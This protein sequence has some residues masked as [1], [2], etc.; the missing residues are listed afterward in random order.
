MNALS[1][2]NSPPPPP[3]DVRLDSAALVPLFL[4]ERKRLYYLL[5][6]LVGDP[7]EAESL[8]QETFLQAA[9]SLER[10]EGR[11]KA[12]TW[13]R[14]IA[15]NLSRSHRRKA[16]RCRP[17]DPDGLERVQEATPS[18]AGSPERVA[19]RRDEARLV[20][21]ALDRLPAPYREVV[22]LRDLD[23]LSTREVAG[24]LG[25]AEGAVRVR[26]HRA[27]QALAALLAPYAAEAVGD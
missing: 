21:R 24:R 7:H 22:T 26:L 23:G 2:P 4:G 17:L 25:V 18:G 16:A 15:L 14:A 6:R 27:R 20:R 11:A 13:L 12:S 10:F 8:V 1:L 9:L 3:P 5:L 19:I